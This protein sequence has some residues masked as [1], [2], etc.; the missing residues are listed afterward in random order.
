MTGPGRLYVSPKLPELNVLLTGTR[1]PKMPPRIATFARVQIEDVHL[2]K[3]IV[4]LALAL[5][6]QFAA[7]MRKIT[8]PTPPAFED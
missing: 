2:V 5:K 1:H 4:F 7:I 6:N 3:R 8:F